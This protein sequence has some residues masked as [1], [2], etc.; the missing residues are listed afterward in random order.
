MALHKEMASGLEPPCYRCG[1]GFQAG[2]MK[3]ER[4]HNGPGKLWVHEG[5]APSTRKGKHN[6]KK[7][8]PRPQ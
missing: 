4:R 5:C 7:A 3:I 6:Q 1:R 2:D 8:K